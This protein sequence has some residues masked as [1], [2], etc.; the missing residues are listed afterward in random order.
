VTPDQWILLGIVA[1]AMV[2]F[3]SERIRPD[4][5]GLLVLLA[6][7]L[8]NV[9]DAGEAFSGFSNPAVITVGAMFVLSVGTV[10]AGVPEALATLISR[11]GGSRLWTVTISLMVVV[12]LMSAFMNNI[13][14]TVIL[15]PAAVT[16]ARRNQATASKLLIPLS[17]GSL[18]GGLVTLVGTPPN[19]L[20]SEALAAAGERPFGMF[21]FAPTG[22]VIFGVGILYMVT[23]GRRLL[24][25]RKAPGVMSELEQTRQFLGEIVVSTE[26]KV[27]GKTLIELG[28]RPRFGVSVLEIVHQGRKNRF[29]SASDAIYIGDVL[30]VDGERDE[31]VRLVEE[32]EMEFAA[33][34]EVR[35]SLLESEDAALVELVAGPGFG[36][37]GKSVADVGFRLKFGG[38]V[39]GIW[40]Q[41]NPVRRVLS[42]V[43]IRPGDVLLVRIPI[44]RLSDLTMSQEFIL[45]EQRSRAVHPR[46]RMFVPVAILAIVISLAATGTAHISVAGTLGVVLMLGL[47]VIPYERFYASVE[48]KILVLIGTLMPLGLAMESTGLA[49]VVAGQVADFLEPG[50]AL[51]ILAGLFL[52]TALMTQIM[53]NAAAVVLVAPLAL[54]MA[55]ATGISPH[56]VMMI[57]AISGSTAFLT[58]IGHQANVLVYNTGGYR[59]FDFVRVG[60]PL[61]LII[62]VA[63]LIIVPIVWPL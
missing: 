33:E 14:A 43:K 58:P 15:I 21:D 27:V 55:A 5:V 41:G 63:S 42:R 1:G 11:W 57:V 16:L 7:V 9:I 49:E 23:I 60:G 53:S 62:L 37:G 4:V 61:T 36:D 54:Q 31:I 26:A 22:V 34:G 46:P 6:L 20:A 51:T 2:L 13:A 3:A 10:E 38:L 44:E 47:R 50:G 18:L 19:L 48:W 52:L 17:F 29:P 25:E 24:P 39:L 32:E 28:W 30:L 8:S 59:F 45:L 12:G 40:R 35:D 56:A